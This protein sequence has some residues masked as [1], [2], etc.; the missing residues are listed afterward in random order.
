MVYITTVIVPP[1]ILG[2]LTC[3]VAMVSGRKFGKCLPVTLLA[4][5]LF[6]YYVQ[7][8][9]HTFKVCIISVI[10]G[11]II[12]VFLVFKKQNKEN[13]FSI[14]MLS[15]IA[16]VVIF[17]I[18]D[19]GRAFSK[20][21]E[22][23]HWGMMTKEMYRLDKFYS[24]TINSRLLV[25]LEYPPFASIFEMLWCKLSG[26]YTEMGATI[27][28]HVFSLSLLTPPL[29]EAEDY[30]GKRGKGILKSLCINLTVIL[31]IMYWNPEK[32]FMSIY[33][34]VFL[35]L[36]FVYGMLLITNEDVYKDKFDFVSLIMVSIALSLTKQM[37]I[38][39]DIILW[40]YFILEFMVRE[41]CDQ[42][43]KTLRANISKICGQAIFLILPSL[44]SMWI[45]S[46][47]IN[48]LGIEQGQFSLHKLS[49]SVMIDV[50]RNSASQ[51]LRRNTLQSFLIGLFTKNIA[52]SYMTISY[53]AASILI[54][55][56]L[57]VT[58]KLG[59]KRGFS[60]K[61]A[62]VLGISLGCGTCGWALIMAILYLFCF[63]ES[64]MKSLASF[65]R[66]MSSYVLSEFM[67]LFLLSYRFL[68]KRSDE[69]KMNLRNT[70]FLLCGIFAL[71]TENIKVFMPLIIAGIPQYNY[72]AYADYIEEKT[73]G[74]V[75]VFIVDT[76]TIKSQYYINYYADDVRI[77][78]CYTDVLNAD[79]ANEV[80]KG[81]IM[82]DILQ[83]EYIFFLYVN[84]NL[85]SALAYLNDNAYFEKTLYHVVQEDSFLLEKV[86]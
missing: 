52:Q 78:L 70:S 45:W 3:T 62:I 73:D 64:E 19:F 31:V 35:A 55:L 49:A 57:Y 65:E 28:L 11:A 23:S 82:S 75:D 24:D 58:W 84:E 9:F 79:Y 21:D 29:M 25:H 39:F 34:D 83:N 63:S 86:E 36:L 61:E 7:F 72:K 41:C 14:G 2:M 43:L 74:T 5:T 51:R 13:V 59:K 15:F 46:T 33:K 71:N 1:V 32:D 16:I 10:L 8:V 6:M 48:K 77:R 22:F 44:F 47:Y 53:V 81:N 56:F 85:N 30:K 80:V 66:Y 38:A 37:G 69:W 76:D 20:W 42:G 17:G 18:V 60:N 68:L 26:K 40:F 54:V 4:I 67:I 27:G 12:G 50:L